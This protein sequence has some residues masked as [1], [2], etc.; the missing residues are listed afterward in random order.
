M[1]DSSAWR[2]TQQEMRDVLSK[3]D[4]AVEDDG[5]YLI[6]PSKRERQL[7][8]KDAV[9][10]R[11]DAVQKAREVNQRFVETVLSDLGQETVDRHVADMRCLSERPGVL[12]TTSYGSLA[13]VFLHLFRDWTIE[14]EHVR[15][16]TYEPAIAALKN[17]VPPGS[18]VLLPGAGLGRFALEL[19]KEGYVVE[20]NDASRLFLT[21]ADYILNR[22]PEGGLRLLPLAHVF[23]ENWGYAQQY[24][25]V[26]VPCPRP[27]SLTS[28]LEG[29]AGPLISFVCGDFIKNYGYG[30][31][32]KRKFDAVVTC[33][34][35]DTVTDF[36]E[37]MDT[38]DGL[39]DVGGV[40]LNVGPLNWRKEARLKLAWSEI[41][42][43]WQNLGYE[44]VSQESLDCDYH[45]KRGLKMYTESYNVSL[46]VAVKRRA[47]DDE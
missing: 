5:Y 8:G 38:V 34:F 16:S 42:A 30:C 26:Q 12:P 35:I 46:T 40:W 29:E 10:R 44:F 17:H 15:Q 3:Y 11:S 14:C 45:L 41:T 9:A 19:A 23:S 25:E 37:L 22:A 20:A 33:F 21:F 7:L 43:M 1:S 31:P 32:G 2:M 4:K 6:H 27:E 39:L 47:S 36:T 13:S 18:A 24:I 28:K